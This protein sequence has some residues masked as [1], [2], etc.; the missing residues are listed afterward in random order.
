[1]HCL[2]CCCTSKQQVRERCERGED[3]RRE[4]V[5]SASDFLIFNTQSLCCLGLILIII[6]KQYNSRKNGTT[7]SSQ[8]VLYD[9]MRIDNHSNYFRFRQLSNLLDIHCMRHLT[10]ALDQF[11][12]F[13]STTMRSFVFTNLGILTSK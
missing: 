5:Q 4:P 8:L 9:A 12:A 2:T 6:Y 7:L 10:T 11:L 13:T 3:V 1:M